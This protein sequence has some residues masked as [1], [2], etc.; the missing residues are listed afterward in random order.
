MKAFC[1]R[2]KKALLQLCKEARLGVA[3]AA[4]CCG[5]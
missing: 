2:K 4:A 3:A 5:K 1:L